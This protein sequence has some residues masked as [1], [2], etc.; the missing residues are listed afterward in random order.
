M[1]IHTV[2]IVTVGPGEIE[3]A[4]LLNCNDIT[5]GMFSLSINDT[6]FPSNQTLIL[7][8]LK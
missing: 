8:A 6:P 7:Y 4:T 2:M 1:E 3:I 5:L